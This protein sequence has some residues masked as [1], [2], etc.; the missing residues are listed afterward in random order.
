MTVE[1]RIAD[2]LFRSDGKSY[3]D[4]CLAATLELSLDQIKEGTIPLAEEGW[5]KR[6]VAPCAICNSVKL[7]SKRRIGSFAA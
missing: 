5:T 3:C 4:E 6:W 2:Y 7:V 1:D